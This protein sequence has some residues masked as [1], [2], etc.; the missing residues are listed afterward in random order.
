MWFTTYIDDGGGKRSKTLSSA[1]IQK[2]EKQV[3]VRIRRLGEGLGT[4]SVII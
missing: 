4:G 2:V 1:G 3:A